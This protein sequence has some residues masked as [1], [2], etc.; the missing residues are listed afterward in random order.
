MKFSNLILALPILTVLF[1]NTSFAQADSTYWRGWYETPIDVVNLTRWETSDWWV[2][3]GVLVGGVAL[4]TQDEAIRESVQGFRSPT[5]DNLSK[6]IAEPFGSGYYSMGAT[7]IAYGAGWAFKDEKLRRTSLQAAKAYV[8]TAGATFVLKQLTHRSRPYESG[9]DDLWYGPYALTFENDG[10]PSGHTS[11]AFAVA[12][13]YAHAYSDRPWLQVGLYSVAGLTALSRM[14]D[15]KH[16]AS[17]VFIGAALGWY[18][19]RTIV[20]TDSQLTIAP[21]GNGIYLSWSID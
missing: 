12:S 15:D 1:S 19:G 3:S 7:A 20:K 8:L 17:D 21:S 5:T 6:Y 9:R 2:A 4:Y 16:W 14:N 10:F 13:V 11:T 18:I